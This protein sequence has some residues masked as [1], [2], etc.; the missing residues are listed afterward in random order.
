MFLVGS[1]RNCL[2][3]SRARSGPGSKL[4]GLRQRL[5]DK[6]TSVEA[7]I[8]SW[9]ESGTVAELRHGSNYGYLLILA[10]NPSSSVD[11]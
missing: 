7:D 5:Q 10:L 8:Q 11:R 4:V 6:R 3:A 9:L 2:F 1:G